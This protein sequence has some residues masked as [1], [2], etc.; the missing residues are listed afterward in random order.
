MRHPRLFSWHPQRVDFATPPAN[1]T[2]TPHQRCDHKKSKLIG[3]EGDVIAP[4]RAVV[5]LFH[6][7]HF[8]LLVVRFEPFEIYPGGVV[9]Q[10]DFAQRVHRD[11]ERIYRFE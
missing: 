1:D 10:F 3:I 11:G 6:H 9:A 5:R 4:A 8:H 2:E 7:N